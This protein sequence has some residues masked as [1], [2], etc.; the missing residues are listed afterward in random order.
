MW[1][2][3]M[4]GMVQAQLA[5]IQTRPKLH[6]QPHP[7]QRHTTHRQKVWAT[8]QTCGMGGPTFECS[9]TIPTAPN[10]RVTATSVSIITSPA[11]QAHLGTHT[12]S[13]GTLFQHHRCAAVGKRT[14][15]QGQA[16]GHDVT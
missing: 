4:A 15:L 16:R 9:W 6:T 13:Q 14:S 5:S 10:Q 11:A 2:H 8:V 1:W 3:G 7:P 12:I